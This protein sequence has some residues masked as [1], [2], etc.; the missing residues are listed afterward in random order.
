MDVRD[1]SGKTVLVT[2]HRDDLLRD[3][4]EVVQLD[5]G[6]IVGQGMEDAR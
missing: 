4:D 2:G 1:L 5:R 6:E 3:A